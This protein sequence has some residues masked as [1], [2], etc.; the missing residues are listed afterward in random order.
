MALIDDDR[1]L[2]LEVRAVKERWGEAP[3]LI[4]DA[5]KMLYWELTVTVHGRSFP[6]HVIYPPG[7]PAAAPQIKVLGGTDR[8]APA[9]YG[10]S[11]A[12]WIDPRERGRPEDAWDPGR[13]TAAEVITVAYRWCSAYLVWE[14]TGNWPQQSGHA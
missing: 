9:Q 14:A 2:A 8:N 5:N 6:L 12:C 11:Y 4:L 3:K 10:D 13:D 7:Y 1:R